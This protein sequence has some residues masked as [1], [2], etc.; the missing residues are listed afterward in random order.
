MSKKV[1]DSL[2]RGLEEAIAETKGEKTEIRWRTVRVPAQIDLPLP[3]DT[4]GRNVPR[5]RS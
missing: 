3:V 1:F 4:A 2:R 5:D